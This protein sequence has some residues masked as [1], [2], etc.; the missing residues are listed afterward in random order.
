MITSDA[1]RRESIR[2]PP[3]ANAPASRGSGEVPCRRPQERRR[4]VR[5]RPPEVGDDPLAGVGRWNRL[6]SLKFPVL[7]N[8]GTKEPPGATVAWSDHSGPD[9]AA[10]RR[11]QARAQENGAALEVTRYLLTLKLQGQLSVMQQSDDEGGSSHVATVASGLER[12]AAAMSIKDIL[13]F[14]AKAA[15]AYWRVWEELPVSFAKGTTCQGHW[16]RVGPRHSP[17]SSGPR[18]ATTPAHAI[19]NYCHATTAMRSA[20][21][22]HASRCW[23]SASIRASVGSTATPSIGRALLW[24][25]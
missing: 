19:L 6:A 22:N 7:T 18:A 23:R 14:E 1:V 4:P 9:Q 10:L 11:A 15:N 13:T 5:H 3:G 21:S 16:T 24:T 8:G 20:S 2:R 17:L 25:S 12:V